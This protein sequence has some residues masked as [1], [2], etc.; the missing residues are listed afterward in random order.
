MSDIKQ[1]INFKTLFIF[2]HIISEQRIKKLI[3]VCFDATLNL[4]LA[5]EEHKMISKPNI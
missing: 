5:A 3:A 4:S 1:I 2:T